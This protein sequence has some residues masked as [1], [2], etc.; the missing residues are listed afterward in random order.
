MS[1]SFHRH[2]F[3]RAGRRR[4]DM[5]NDLHRGSRTRLNRDLELSGKAYGKFDSDLSWE[6]NAGIPGPS[7]EEYRR[8][9]RAE[10]PNIPEKTLRRE[11]WKK[12]RMK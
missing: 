5:K 10:D 12:Y 2:A 1:R 11:Y 8:K 3:E 7:W 4:R 6:L 9:R